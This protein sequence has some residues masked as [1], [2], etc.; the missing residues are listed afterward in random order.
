MELIG[1]ATLARMHPTS[2]HHHPECEQRMA[3]LLDRFDVTPGRPATRIEVERVHDSGYLDLLAGLRLEGWLDGDTLAGPT[4]W[5]AALL[6]AGCAIE[7]VDRGGFA[8][9][10]PPGHHALRDRAMGFCL[11]GNVAIAV[12]HAQHT[13]GI[14]RVAVVDWD[15]HHG[16]GTE[17]M[18]R[19]DDS[20]LFV[21]LHQWPFWPGSGGPGTG[22]ETTINIPLAAGSGDDDYLLA[23][24]EI[25]APAIARFAPGLVI[26][27][28]GF[29]AHADDPL[30]GMR[31]TAEGFRA[32]G[33]RVASYAPRVAAV[34]EG[35]YNLSTLPALVAAALDGLAIGRRPE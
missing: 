2:H 3:L 16:N 5:D 34:L 29:D 25:V 10:R 31:V 12:R 19:G 18:F 8:L 32:M 4:S 22:D 30:A 24:D 17:E 7:A 21:S 33:A 13:L 9:V 1:D 26:V 28:A 27:S 15:V 11:L 20:V 35:G 14:E 6:A 23:L